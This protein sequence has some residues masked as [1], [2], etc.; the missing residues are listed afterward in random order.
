MSKNLEGQPS[1]E[2]LVNTSFEETRIAILEDERV[3]ELIWERRG[4]LNIVGNIY[5]GTVETYCP[6]FPAHF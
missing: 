2:V 6:A 5:K 3:N 1:V 4:S